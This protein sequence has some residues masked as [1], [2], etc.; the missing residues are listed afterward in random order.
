MSAGAPVSAP[1]GPSGTAGA[2]GAEGTSPGTVP[3]AGS[4]PV[5]V[6]GDGSTART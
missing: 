2:E 3:A 1:A 4:G 5:V 6:T